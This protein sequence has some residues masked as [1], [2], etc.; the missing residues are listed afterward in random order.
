MHLSVTLKCMTA[1]HALTQVPKVAKTSMM[2]VVLGC[3][4][5]T[6][7]N[8]NIFLFAVFHKPNSMK[9]HACME[10]SL[11]FTMRVISILSVFKY[12]YCTRQGSLSQ[13]YMASSLLPLVAN[14]MS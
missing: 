8:H 4:A 13:P 10:L 3:V 7:H 6:Y 12:I 2:Q 1:V 14:I 5:G 9:R 11:H